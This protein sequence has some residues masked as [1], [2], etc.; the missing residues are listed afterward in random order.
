MVAKAGYRAAFLY[1]ANCVYLPEHL[2][3][4]DAYRLD[5]VAMGPDTDLGRILGEAVVRSTS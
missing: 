5:R 1:A 4:G 2:P 3:V